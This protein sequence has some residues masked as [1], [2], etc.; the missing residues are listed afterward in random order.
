M[1]R[2]EAGQG[3]RD[4]KGCDGTVADF[5]KKV[6]PIYLFVA[7]VRICHKPKKFH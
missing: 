2:R 6:Q 1:R 4:H 3:A 7:R 5:L